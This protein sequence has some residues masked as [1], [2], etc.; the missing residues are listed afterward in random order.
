MIA[1]RLGSAALVLAALAFLPRVSSGCEVTPRATVPLVLAA[2]R[3]LV[4]V[5]VNGAPATFAL[6]TG[7]D[8]SLVTPEA[9]RRLG[10]ARS[11]WVDATVIGIGGIARYRVADARTLSLGGVS[12][13]ARNVG[14]PILAVAPLGE[15]RAAALVVD[16]QLGRDFLRSF[17]VALNGP[18][19]T[20]TL[21]Q[22]RDCAGRFLPWRAPYDAIPALPAYA[23]ALVLP[24]EANGVT[25]RAL[26]DTGT[27]E[28]LIAAP[29]MARL[30]LV[31]PA[32]APT[33][34]TYGV[35]RFARPVWPV[36]LSSL[37]L[38]DETIRDPI[39]LGSALRAFPIVDLVL[40]A[41]WFRTRRVWLSYATGQ[42]FV[43]V[44]KARAPGIAPP[45]E[46]QH[47]SS[48]PERG[49]P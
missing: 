39:V 49:N 32:S 2:G 4:D 21:W 29:G 35:G 45:R 3:I 38:G 25:L 42:V 8:R 24:V 37:R 11:R 19:R 14:H 47:S 16:G 7:A 33:M 36:H 15:A 40:G 18:A 20:L 13:W 43:N 48:V 28:T 5:A 12:L 27:T 31:A 26:P 17:D 23:D 9:V 1:R 46:D 41:D 6:D 22:V 44:G 10:L 34:R 30:G